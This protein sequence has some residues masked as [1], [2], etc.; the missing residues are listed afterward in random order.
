MPCSSGSVCSLLALLH[1]EI[2]AKHQELTASLIKAASQ[3]EMLP[4]LDALFT[5]GEVLVAKSTDLSEAHLSELG[6]G[7]DPI[8]LDPPHD[9]WK[10]NEDNSKWVLLAG[11]ERTVRQTIDKK[12]QAEALEVQIAELE[13]DVAEIAEQIVAQEKKN[14]LLETEVP[15]LEPV[16]AL[17]GDEF[18]EAAAAETEEEAEQRRLEQKELAEKE[19]A[20]LQ[21]KKA[22]VEEAIAEHSARVAKLTEEGLRKVDVASL[23]RW[24][25]VRYRKTAKSERRKIAA[26]W[27]LETESVPLDEV[28]IQISR[29]Q[30]DELMA[31]HEIE[32]SVGYLDSVFYRY[33]EDRSAYLD[34]EEF[35]QFA[36][37]VVKKYL[38][39][40]SS[41][42]KGPIDTVFEMIDEDGSGEV[43]MD[44]FVQW[45]AEFG[46]LDAARRMQEL[47]SRMR[48]LLAE[49]VAHEGA[50][51]TAKQARRELDL[52]IGEASIYQIFG[53]KL[54]GKGAWSID[55][56]A[57]TLR[58]MAI[59]ERLK[60][61][62]HNRRYSGAGQSMRDELGQQQQIAANQRIRMWAAEEC[63]ELIDP[64]SERALPGT[65]NEL[66]IAAEIEFNAA[67]DAVN[68][69]QFRC[70][71]LKRERA[72][73]HFVRGR[74][75]A[76]AKLQWLMDRAKAMEPDRSAELRRVWAAVDKDK[77]GDLDIDE[78]KQVLKMMGRKN[79]KQVA[80]EK[81]WK[82]IDRDGDGSVDFEEF[83][84]WYFSQD[85]KDQET[86]LSDPTPDPPLEDWQQER[87]VL[88][89]EVVAF[90]QNPKSGREGWTQCFGVVYTSSYQKTWAP[91]VFLWANE[92]PGR[93]EARYKQ[94]QESGGK[95]EKP[96]LKFSLSKP[97]G[98][99]TV[100]E[101]SEGRLMII[102]I[103]GKKTQSPSVLRLKGA[104]NRQTKDESGL[105]ME[106]WL[107][108]LSDA[109]RRPPSLTPPQPDPD[110]FIKQQATWKDGVANFAMMA[111]AARLRAEE[112]IDVA[113][114]A[115]GKAEDAAMEL[116]KL[117]GQINAQV[118]IDGASG[119]K[120][121]E[122]ADAHAVLASEGL[123]KL[124]RNIIK[125]QRV[126]TCASI[127]ALETVVGDYR[128]DKG[129]LSA[130][131]TALPILHRLAAIAPNAAGL[132][133]VGGKQYKQELDKLLNKAE[134][135]LDAAQSDMQSE[136]EDLTQA[137]VNHEKVLREYHR[138]KGLYDYVQY[139]GNQ[140]LSEQAMSMPIEEIRDMA[141][142]R[143][144]KETKAKAESNVAYQMF[145]TTQQKLLGSRAKRLMVEMYA[146]GMLPNRDELEAHIALLTLDEIELAQD[147]VV[148]AELSSAQKAAKTAFEAYGGHLEVV[149]T[150]I[151]AKRLAEAKKTDL[152]S[153]EAMEG[154]ARY[155]K[156]EEKHSK[157]AAHD[158]FGAGGDKGKVVKGWKNRAMT[159]YPA[160]KIAGAARAALRLH[161]QMR[162][163]GLAAAWCI[164]GQIG[165]SQATDELHAARGGLRALAVLRTEL[166]RLIQGGPH[167]GGN[168]KASERFMAKTLAAREAEAK[169][170]MTY[171]GSY[172]GRKEQK[173]LAWIAEV[174]GMP[175]RHT[176]AYQP[177]T[178]AEDLHSG[179]A[180]CELANRLKPGIIEEISTS[181]L[182]F[183]QRENVGHFVHA[184]PALGLA[185]HEMFM[186]EDLFELTQKRQM[187]E[188]IQAVIDREKNKTKALQDQAQKAAEADALTAAAAEA[189]AFADAKQALFQEAETKWDKTSRARKA[190]K[191]EAKKAMDKAAKVRDKA[192]AKEQAAE[193]KARA[194]RLAV[195]EAQKA[196]EFA[197][198]EQEKNEGLIITLKE[199]ITTALKEKFLDIDGDGDID[200][201]ALE[202]AFRSFDSSDDGDIDYDEFRKALK[203]TLGVNAPSKQFDALCTVLD[204]DG[205]GSINYAEFVEWVGQQLGDTQIQEEEV[206]RMQVE[207]EESTQKVLATIFALG[208]A[209]YNLPGYCGPCLGRP[210][211]AQAALSGAHNALD[212]A[213]AMLHQEE[214]AANQVITAA[215]HADS[216]RWSKLFNR[217]EEQHAAFE[218][219]A[220]EPAAVARRQL[221]VVETEIEPRSFLRGALCEL[222]QLLADVKRV[223]T[224]KPTMELAALRPPPPE[225][226]AAE[227][228]AA[229]MLASRFR[230]RLAKSEL[231]MRKA[232]KR[233]RQAQEERKYL[234]NK[235]QNDGATKIGAIF[236][237]MLTR[238]FYEF[239]KGQADAKAAMEKAAE[240]QKA[241]KIEPAFE[242]ET[243]LALVLAHSPN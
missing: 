235:A 58:S 24:N 239:V 118:A 125:T 85:P 115:V 19:L 148:M 14:E 122:G 93:G 28:N 214:G 101:G 92:K 141:T 189:K 53:S 142:K 195:M 234:R 110:W 194:A 188:E 18:A 183:P 12:A 164:A 145:V 159:S 237:G 157:E 88:E 64:I 204:A 126:L 60:V 78:L 35:P 61:T 77:S 182:P 98:E 83:E 23:F 151:L 226:G 135:D 186:P 72:K 156:D 108:V 240:F 25:D 191:E 32:M 17:E 79:I 112:L 223:Q 153:A 37:V 36:S 160:P 46:K 203:E 242:C 211:V 179:V 192:S 5:K 185:V 187:I 163:S 217:L 107:N 140:A 170:S 74:L 82:V 129:R 104:T 70:L 229:A 219:A 205:D 47:K 207:I 238:R 154:M 2:A 44:E 8:D 113:A 134:E 230:A 169:D 227:E 127:C 215:M 184:L 212:E 31:L 198:E 243:C 143:L 175:L 80:L 89:E 116:C 41:G 29:Q 100:D 137:F 206:R 167:I 171:E 11:E 38:Q 86:M 49:A 193:D 30:V 48:E 102:T 111:S 201:G 121:G 228:G 150:A 26:G 218:E 196:A 3:L 225:F 39:L 27:V 13:V 96:M 221:A 176:G 120:T 15:E 149:Q 62:A 155:S 22:A 236:K 180:L 131:K 202:E 166:F 146:G 162:D 51:V 103:A 136:E 54:D 231:E 87:V 232:Q 34:R 105:L 158:L 222:R 67:D 119:E 6:A 10:L 209:A 210:E 132:G 52:A 56:H 71:A 178:L 173:A 57:E 197:A 90:C 138:A 224:V 65:S 21:G 139:S 174:T 81:V 97:K 20:E 144:D 117:H 133:G 9:G 165:L 43:E 109:V 152:A 177:Y 59:I 220:K 75:K 1:A 73:M 114:Q 216:E 63:L 42:P 84:A 76:L 91:R 50:K 95:A 208:A 172:T 147:S 199:D 190:E 181:P 94:W 99:A 40:T 200:H 241:D 7:A 128:G 45:W 123:M 69:A 233:G 33:D 68:A 66:R 168:I 55:T 124:K 106:K 4:G 213:L 130:V 161:E 16:E